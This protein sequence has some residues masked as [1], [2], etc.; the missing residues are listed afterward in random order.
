M[1][2]FKLFAHGVDFDP[3]SFLVSTNMNFDG[4]W[5]KGAT[6]RD[7]PKSNG[8]FRFLG[9]GQELQLDEQQKLAIDFLSANHVA[10]KLLATF[11]GVTTF[12][13]G[14]Q[15]NLVAEPGLISFCMSPSTSLMQCC[16]DVG[17]TPTY[18]VVLDTESGRR[19]S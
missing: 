8:V 7:H 3:D 19:P 12:I 16:L 5:H 15:Y 2:Q 11:P 9:D 14:L 1:N 17:I 10:L 6:G 13:L 4:A 18:Y